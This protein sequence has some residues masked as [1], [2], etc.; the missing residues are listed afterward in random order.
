[1]KFL[2]LKL[3]KLSTGAALDTPNLTG[4]GE[5]NNAAKMTYI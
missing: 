1:M 5:N 3:I 4:I 2:H